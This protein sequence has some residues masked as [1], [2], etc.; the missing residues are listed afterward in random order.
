[1]IFAKQ[2]INLVK[3]RL[4][5]FKFSHLFF[6]SASNLRMQICEIVA[7]CKLR[8]VL[9]TSKTLNLADF[10]LMQYFCAACQN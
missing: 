9:K 4:V 7:R 1:M 8:L 10:A 6:Y 3:F 5:N 2:G